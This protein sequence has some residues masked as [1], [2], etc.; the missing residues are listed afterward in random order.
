MSAAL[1]RQLSMGHGWARRARTFSRMGCLRRAT[2]ERPV[3]TALQR[4]SAQR[5]FVFIRADSNLVQGLLQ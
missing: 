5:V 1:R 4:E 2:A 3:R